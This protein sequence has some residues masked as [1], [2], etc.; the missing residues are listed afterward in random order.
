MHPLDNAV[1]HALTGPH[2]TVAQTCGDGARRYPSNMAHFAA[3]PDEPDERAWSDLAS[4]HRPTPAL[5][6]RAKVP[7]PP[8][9]WN[10][11]VQMPTL[12]MVPP[13]VLV[14]APEA[15]IVPLG[16]ADVPAMIDLVARTRPGPF[17]ERTHEMGAYFGIKNQGTLVAMAG[18][19]MRLDAFT[20]VSAVCTDAEFRGRGYAAALVH[21]VVSH[22]RA[23]DG[24]AFLHVLVENT[25]AIRVYELLG[26]T[27]RTEIDAQV[28]A[29]SES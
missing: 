21:R 11:V 23:N 28:I 18:E 13:S 15:P 1:W 7:A 26:W 9:G 4:L 16:P 25:S 22:I 27:V 12:Q 20:E 3:I 29:Y 10:V 8:P 19:R 5:L 6:F 14:P 2:E 24:E 17:M